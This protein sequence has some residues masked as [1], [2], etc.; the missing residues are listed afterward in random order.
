MVVRHVLIAN[1]GFTFADS[2]N[3]EWKMT[4]TEN[5][6]E[7]KKCFCKSEFRVNILKPIRLL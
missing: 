1:E 4:L 2:F 3:M 7:N 6:N 5:E